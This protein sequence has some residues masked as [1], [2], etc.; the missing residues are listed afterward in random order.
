MAKIALKVEYDGS[1]FNG[2]QTN[3]SGRFV[4]AELE[5]ALSALA[6]QP[7]N[8]TCAGRTDAGVH[9]SGQIIHFES[10]APRTLQA[11]VQG[12]N[13][14]L[15]AD[16]A[17]QWAALVPE[18]FHAR[19]SA[20]S[21]TYRYVIL[22]VPVRPALQ[23]SCV[24]WCYTPLNVRL[25]QEAAVHLLGEH[26]FNAY[27][28]AQCQSKTSM[29]CVQRCEVTRHQ[30]HIIME[31]QANAFLHH[32]VRNIMGVLLTIGK[33]TEP[34]EW[35]KTVLDSKDRRCASITAFASGLSLI[36]VEY[37]AEFQLPL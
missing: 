3:L 34:P 4:Q 28:S 33:G 19:Y 32:M 18:H 6:N 14:Y 11:F 7:I 15:P 24:T 1:A 27:R 2:W 22:N 5:Q 30:D 10:S 29:R 36:Q 8:V 17:V 35:A 26:D 23:R 13:R 37:P 25:M 9:A 31:I 16:I 21:R 12:T 20:L